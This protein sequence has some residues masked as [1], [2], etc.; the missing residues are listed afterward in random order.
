MVTGDHKGRE[1]RQQSNLQKLKKRIHYYAGGQE[2]RDARGF[3]F[4]LCSWGLAYQHYQ[5]SW[6]KKSGLMNISTSESSQ[7]SIESKPKN[8]AWNI[9]DQNFRMED[10]GGPFTVVE[11]VELSLY[12]KY[13]TDQARTAENWCSLCQGLVY[14][15]Q[16]CLFKP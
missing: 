10:A 7:H 9:Y 4:H 1:E 12:A 2:G 6:W 13:F 16:K 14:A 3:S 11:N 15:S 5:K 8:T